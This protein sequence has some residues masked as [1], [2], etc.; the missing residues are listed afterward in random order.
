MGAAASAAGWSSVAGAAS[1]GQRIDVHAHFIPTFFR[2]ALAAHGVEGDG[3][4]P[5]PSWSV[6]EA[7]GFMD[8][9]GIQA[10]VVSLCMRPVKAS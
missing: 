5:L 7:L 10:Q 2:Q 9:F 1:R 4:I 3:G 6:S 8:K